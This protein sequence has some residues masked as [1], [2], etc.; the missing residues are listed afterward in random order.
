MTTVALASTQVMKRSGKRQTYAS[1]KVERFLTSLMCKQPSLGDISPKDVCDRAT[2]GS[3]MT[4]VALADHLAE[5]CA[6][7]TV[8]H[9]QFG[10]LGGRVVISM[11]HR[12]T[13][14]TFCESMLQLEDALAPEFVDCCRRNQAAL[15]Q[16][17]VDDRDFQYNIMGIR[18]LQRSY[19]LKKN[20]IIIERPQYMLMRVAVALHGDNLDMVQKTYDA[21]SRL[22][23]THA[24]PTLF[25]AGMKKQQL[26]SCFL[27]TMTDDSIEGIFETLKRCALISKGAGGIGLSCSNIRAS[28]SAILGTNGT[29]NG[30][31]PMLRVFNDTA[32]Y[33]DQCVVPE[34]IIYTI[35]GPKAIHQLVNDTDQVINTT[36][37][38]AILNVLE[39][40]YE[41]DILHVKTMH[42]I[43]P[44]K[45]TPEHPL[46]ALRD[47]GKG[48]NFKKTKEKIASG[49]NV[50][51]WID[52]KDVRPRDFIGF[53]IPTYSVD[54]ATI[55]E[56]DCY[57]YGVLLGDG[58]LEF[59]KPYGK[60]ILHT[61]TKNHILEWLKT[62]FTNRCVHY[63]V[64]VDGLTTRIRWTKSTVLPIKYGDVYNQGEKYVHP[65]WLNLPVEKSKYIVKGL[66]DTDGCI[67]K[68]FVFDSTSRHLI[69]S[70]RYILMRMRVLTSGYVRDRR[71]ESHMTKR[72]IITNQKVSYSLRLPKTDAVCDLLGIERCGR[73]FKFFEH[74]DILYSRVQDVD[75]ESYEGTLYDLQM[76]HEHAYVTHNGM[77]HN[78]GGRRKGS[79]AI[80][81]EPHHPDILD[82]LELKKNHGVDAEKA[83]DLFYGLWISDIFMRRV[84]GNQPWSVICPTQCPA[85][86]DAV[87]DEYTRLYEECEA[88][89]LVTQTFP[90]ARE[91]FFAILD[92]QIETG[93]PYMMYKD[94]CNRKSN[95]KHLGTIRGSNLCCEIVEY[96]SP[97][98]AAVC[99][100]AS[101]SLTACASVEGFDFKQLETVTRLVTRNLNRTIDCNYYPIKQARTSNER[102][103]PIGIG[104]QGLADVF[105]IL[106]LPYE[107]TGAKALNREIFETLY[108]AALDE[109]VE[110]AKRD[111]PYASF[112]GSPFSQGLTQIELWNQSITDARH[113]WS[114]L[115]QKLQQ[116]G[117]RNSLLTAPMPTA[118]T[119]SIMGNTESFE[120]RTSNLYTR[121]VLS[122]EYI[123]I[124]K[125]LQQALV[126]RGLWSDAMSSA[127]I[128]QR[129][130]VQKIPEVPDDIKAVFKTVWELSQRTVID[131]A[132][133]RGPFI[134][135][136][137]SLNI[138]IEEPT[139][140]ILTSVHFYTWQKGLKTGQYY[141]RT[142]PK[143][144]ALQFTCSVKKQKVEDDEDECMA[145]SA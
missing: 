118:S 79:F 140:A 26:A 103:R 109:S 14:S 121:R 98:E 73:F 38:E 56:E 142:Q 77:V 65:K 31:A 145:C 85:L 76:K 91:V 83:R 127:L 3:N 90:S 45:I 107:S 62:Y 88:N 28:G 61:E 138:H 67:Y 125:Y 123:V 43:E 53:P 25:H 96:T 68:E 115:R 78:G 93:T 81:L 58:T 97:D 132:A 66:M 46:Y 17:I 72:G 22:L 48:F 52:A 12:Q 122:G 100:L 50:P 92:S 20:N 139:R 15:N 119:A 2:L 69:E 40:P 124:N 64:R 94:H 105:Q 35:D 37:S 134:D 102:H 126:S 114:Q 1:G 29:S 110:L 39:H 30:L 129:G 23:Y 54:I 86:Q 36:G 16:M 18:T 104:V 19:L 117:A 10:Q 143:A 101:V 47:L 9:W 49:S 63:T 99:T 120:P 41:G 57:F 44:L 32:R 106:G 87:G 70:M 6:A 34:T 13:P 141:L 11:L 82:F 80:F 112:A 133:D 27:M 7:L 42:S 128:E 144:K 135:Q 21:T 4:T 131:M 108:Y 8:R 59:Q 71:G 111:G 84:K 33:V 74:D 130:S 136:S 55:S 116:F 95:Q 51:T 75:T 113:P 5:V 60:V 89:G 137:Q 24:T